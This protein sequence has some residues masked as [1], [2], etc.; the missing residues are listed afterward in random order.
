MSFG[1]VSEHMIQMMKF[2]QSLGKTTMFFLVFLLYLEDLC[3]DGK[4]SGVLVS[5]FGGPIDPKGSKGSVVVPWTD[6]KLSRDST[7]CDECSSSFW[8]D[9]E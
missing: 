2:P 8:K 9:A 3:S 5:D 1:E 4:F 6:G 7:M